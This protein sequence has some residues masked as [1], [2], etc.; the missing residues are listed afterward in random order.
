MFLYKSFLSFYCHCISHVYMSYCQYILSITAIMRLLRCVWYLLAKLA[1]P[2][3]PLG[4]TRSVFVGVGSLNMN[5]VKVIVKIYCG[6][7]GDGGRA[8]SEALKYSCRSW[9]LCWLCTI[10]LSQ[11]YV[12]AMLKRK[13]ADA[14]SRIHMGTF[15]VRLASC[16]SVGVERMQ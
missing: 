4:W 12:N 13:E 2:N 11:G 14:Q 6:R 15:G 16:F 9:A 1:C 7:F 3:T 10:W 8:V 5:H